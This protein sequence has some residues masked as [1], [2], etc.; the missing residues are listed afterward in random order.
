MY[1]HINHTFCYLKSSDFVNVEMGLFTKYGL[2]YSLIY[3]L[4]NL[5]IKIFLRESSNESWFQPIKATSLLMF[6]HACNTLKQS[7]KP[8]YIHQIHTKTKIYLIKQ[9]CKICLP[10][11]H[12]QK[13][14]SNVTIKCHNMDRSLRGSHTHPL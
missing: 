12:V 4:L 14:F 2:T 9:I 8:I 7:Q 6:T 3:W 11:I 13:S 5:L 1:I 10:K